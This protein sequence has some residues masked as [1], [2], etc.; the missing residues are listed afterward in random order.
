MKWKAGATPEDRR[1]IEKL[2]EA[3]EDKSSMKGEFRWEEDS[4]DPTITVFKPRKGL[5][6]LVRMWTDDPPSNPDQYDVVA[7]TEVED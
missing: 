3:I 6:V 1:L 4:V 5:R 7:I 2:L